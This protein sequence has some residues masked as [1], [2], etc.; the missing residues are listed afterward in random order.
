M[1]ISYEELCSGTEDLE[2]ASLLAFARD[3]VIRCSAMSIRHPVVVRSHMESTV[4]HT[5]QRNSPRAEL[6]HR[7]A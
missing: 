7:K 1:D 3:A 4:I 5:E 6:T 2:V